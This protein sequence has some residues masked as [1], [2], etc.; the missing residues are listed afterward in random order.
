MVPLLA[1]ALYLA[2]PQQEWPL[3]EPPVGP[4]PDMPSPPPAPPAVEPQPPVT[5]PELE[6]VVD[7]R[8]E[9]KGFHWGIGGGGMINP[10]GVGSGSNTVTGYIAALPAVAFGLG[11]V[12]FHIALQVLG[13]F[14]NTAKAL[15]LAADTQ[16]RI[17]FARWFS[18][19]AGPYIGVSLS[20]GVDFAFGPSL[21]PAIIKLGDRGQHEI[22]AWGAYPF[23]LSSSSSNVILLLLSY[24]YMFQ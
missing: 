11:W 7:W 5:E 10:S 16:V 2:A 6:P 18:I 17:N 13:Y 3:P 12:D 21:S 9:R 8:A 1:L 23:I 14:S 4:A 20:P 24:S 19:G 15:F 22:A